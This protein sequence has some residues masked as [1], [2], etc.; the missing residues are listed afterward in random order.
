MHMITPGYDTVTKEVNISDGLSKLKGS[1]CIFDIQERERKN[2]GKAAESAR[3]QLTEMTRMRRH[4]VMLRFM[5]DAKL[6]R[7]S[8][9]D[10]D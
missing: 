5:D 1:K 9:C 2:K 6:V 3:H 8:K 7:E 4:R 10:K